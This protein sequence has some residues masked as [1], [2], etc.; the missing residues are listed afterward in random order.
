MKRLFCLVVVLPAVLGAC[1][2]VRGFGQDMSAA[3]RALSD[4]SEKIVGGE[5]TPAQVPASGSSATPR[6]PAAPW[7]APPPAEPLPRAAQQPEEPK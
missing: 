4:V 7:P 1:N 2:T 6:G 3:G 5:P